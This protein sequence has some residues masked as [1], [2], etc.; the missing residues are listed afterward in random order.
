VL[1]VWVHLSHESVDRRKRPDPLAG[2]NHVVG[3]VCRMAGERG[4]DSSAIHQATASVVMTRRRLRSRYLVSG[5]ET[6][7]RTMGMIWTIPRLFGQNVLLTRRTWTD[8]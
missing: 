5:L 3:P 6:G 4:A 1:R 8:E 7:I 2:L